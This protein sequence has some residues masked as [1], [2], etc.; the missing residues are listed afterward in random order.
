MALTTYRLDA[1]IQKYRHLK[2]L[3]RTHFQ[4]LKPEI[5]LENRGT[6]LDIDPH[7]HDGAERLL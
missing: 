5:L 7:P 6:S 4:S 3:K 1:I 2:L